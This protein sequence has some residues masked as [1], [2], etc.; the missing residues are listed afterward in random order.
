MA[1]MLWLMLAIGIP[2]GNGGRVNSYSLIH[3]MIHGRSLK[4]LLGFLVLIVR[5]ASSV[6]DV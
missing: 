1:E 2:F 6:R 4:V 5:F 3:V